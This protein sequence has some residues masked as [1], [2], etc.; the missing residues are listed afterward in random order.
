VG[1]CNLGGG[2]CVFDLAV[3]GNYVYVA[4]GYGG[5]R[6][7]D[8]SDPANPHEINWIDGFWVGA[9]AAS[10]NIAIMD[11]DTRISIWDVTNPLNPILVGYYSTYE[12]IRDLEIQ[13]QYLFTTGWFDFRVYQ[14]DA[15]L[16][17]VKP[18]QPLPIE[19]NLLP[20]YP[21]P[22][23]SVLTIPF[24]LPIQKEVIINIYN[25]LGQRVKEFNFP[26]LSPGMHRVIWNPQECASGIYLVRMMA[27]GQEYEQKAVLLK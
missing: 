10:G 7:V 25:I 19:F 24:T 21:N 22:F 20:P 27:N 14:C 17:V 4:N 6:I 13:G 1:S 16:N 26:H 2:C 12:Y 9:V 15:L 18:N 5:M 23:N 11:D 8:V 3:A